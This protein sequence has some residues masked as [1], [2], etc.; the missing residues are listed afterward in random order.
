M[1]L[2]E[3]T[4]FK[5]GWLCHIAISVPTAD[6][7]P[8]TLSSTSVDQLADKSFKPVYKGHSGEPENVPFMN[9]CSLDTAL[10]KC[11][12]YSLMGNMKLHFLWNDILYRGVL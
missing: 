7:D 11:M 12:H 1:Y 9:N 10:K 6:Y 5:T 2:D 4:T 8:I 3:E